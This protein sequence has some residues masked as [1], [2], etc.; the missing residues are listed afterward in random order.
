MATPQEKLDSLNRLRSAG[1]ITNEQYNTAIGN[2]RAQIQQP[3]TVT[4]VN[5]TPLQQEVSKTA[6][7]SDTEDERD[8]IIDTLLAVAGQRLATGAETATTLVTGAAG[9]VV[10]GLGGLGDLLAGASPEEASQTI[11]NIQKALTFQPRTEA[12]RRGLQ[13]LAQVSQQAG[14]FVQPVTQPIGEALEPVQSA[15]GS[16]LGQALQFTNLGQSLSPEQRE[17]LGQTVVRTAP[18]AA[19]EVAG[20]RFGRIPDAQAPEIQRTTGVQELET[21]AGAGAIEQA[22]TPLPSEAQFGDL[23]PAQRIAQT[24]QESIVDTQ[25]VLQQLTQSSKKAS[26]QL[27]KQN[28]SARNAVDQVLTELATPESVQAVG[29][30]APEAAKAAVR[31]AKDIRDEKASPLFNE[32][33]EAAPDIENIKLDNF[34]SVISEIRADVGKTG[35]IAR[36][37]NKWEKLVDSKEN[38][39]QLHD[40]KTD[41]D[42]E[43]SKLIPQGKVPGKVERASAKVDQAIRD[44][45]R[46]QVPGYAE[47][48]DAFR[49][50][51]PDVDFVTDS[52]GNLSNLTENSKRLAA[53]SIFGPDADTD[54]IKIAKKILTNEQPGVWNSLVRAEINR[55]LGKA[56]TE[57]GAETGIGQGN[58]PDRMVKSIFGND[59]DRAN[60]FA[61]LSGDQRANFAALENWL[62]RA[63][64]GRTTGSP[65][66]PRQELFERL[67]EGPLKSL[68]NTVRSPIQSAD[69]AL[70]Q[71]RFD[72]GIQSIA[73]VFLNPNFSNDLTK[74]R[75]KGP[76]NEASGLAM[77]EL[78]RQAAILQEAEDGTNTDQ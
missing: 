17:A 75:K 64:V 4:E 61:A 21:Q 72:Q 49:Q 77:T 15:V 53:S 56:R 69:K 20:S 3:Q 59:K 36:L 65:T 22:A 73:E 23:L 41:I 5:K 42:L 33:F 58:V 32:A 55:R 11:A 43:V 78:L 63:S 28:E 35:S 37:L 48:A 47:A 16:T 62:S 30:T 2:L 40:A 44:D 68:L 26:E 13:A 1:T 14:E 74:I 60:L 38:A 9:T 27:A 76:F 52:V 45:L 46:G 71:R 29:R 7:E 50:A 6:E 57:T 67:K 18:L 19:L 51:S 24:G 31:A 8:G 70:E 10:G 39:R 66:A 34:K 54:S 25:A 12:G